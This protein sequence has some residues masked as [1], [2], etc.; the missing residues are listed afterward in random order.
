MLYLLTLQL[1]GQSLEQ[2]AQMPSAKPWSQ[3]SEIC[4]CYNIILTLCSVELQKCS[5]KML[6]DTLLEN[7]LAH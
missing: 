3:V 4:S 6:M 1:R 5:V 2:C 7:L